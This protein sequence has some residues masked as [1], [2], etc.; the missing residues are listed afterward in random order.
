MMRSAVVIFAAMFAAPAVASECDALVAKIVEISG[1]SVVRFP[2]ENEAV[3]RDGD[4]K[5]DI[6][7]KGRT[8]NVETPTPFPQGRFFTLAG[9]VGSLLTGATAASIEAAARRCQQRAMKGAGGAAEE[10]PKAYVDCLFP[11]GAAAYVLIL[12]RR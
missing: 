5:L 8:L 2:T 7:C 6:G 10:M 1:A 3:L 4:I 9:Q 12:P 11:R